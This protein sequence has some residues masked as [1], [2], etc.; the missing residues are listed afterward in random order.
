MEAAVTLSCEHQR[1]FVSSNTPAVLVYVL[2]GL[3]YFFAIPVVA[4]LIIAYVKLDECDPV[5]ESHYRFQIRTFW[6]GLLYIVSAI[7][8]CFVLIGFPLMIWWFIWSLMRIVIGGLR[9]LEHRPIVNPRSWL[10][11]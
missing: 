6:I 1:P 7:P 2:Y 11:G 8:L 4:G 5:M 10:F 9:A 3:G